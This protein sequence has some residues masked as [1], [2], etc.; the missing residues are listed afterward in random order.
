M[1]RD[2]VVTLINVLVCVTKQFIVLNL[3]NESNSLPLCLAHFLCMLLYYANKN[4]FKW[5]VCV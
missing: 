3:F 2:E 4:L 5:F 1:H